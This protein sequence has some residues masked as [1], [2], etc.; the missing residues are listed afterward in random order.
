MSED[1]KPSA[2]GEIARIEKAG[3]FVNVNGRI[4]GNLNLSRSLGDMKYKQ[5]GDLMPSEQ[6]ITAEPDITTTELRPDDKFF[7]IAC[8]GVWDVLENQE[9]CDFVSERMY[10]TD[11]PVQFATSG[12]TAA[13]SG[14]SKKP[15]S[16]EDIVK[17]I[18]EYCVAD[19]PKKSQG[20]GG[21]NMTAMIVLLKEK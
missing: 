20:I 8:D 12:A 4:N 7:V 19:D 18:F 14:G 1:H 17:D 9:I 13:F 15:M 2:A 21:D 10:P 5:V 6:M 11:Q 3:G 16:T